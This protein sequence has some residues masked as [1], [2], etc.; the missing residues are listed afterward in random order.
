[1]VEVGP[2]PVDLHRF[3]QTRGESGAQIY[4]DLHRLVVKVGHRFTQIYTD[5]W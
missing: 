5:S 2:L 3:T 4:T 1:V